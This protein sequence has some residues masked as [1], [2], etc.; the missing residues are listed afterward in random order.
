MCGAAQLALCCQP[1][2]HAQQL[3]KDYAITREADVW[4][5]NYLC[6]PRSTACLISCIGFNCACRFSSCVCTSCLVSGRAC[7]DRQLCAN[8]CGHRM[9]CLNC[10]RLHHAMLAPMLP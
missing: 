5:C 2:Q 1:E 8:I 3:S 9:S 6:A 7:M 4:Q 10:A